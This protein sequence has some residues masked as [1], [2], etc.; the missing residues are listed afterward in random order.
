[1]KKRLLFVVCVLLS[2]SLLTFGQ[3]SLPLIDEQVF[4]AGLKHAESLLRSGI[5]EN[6]EYTPGEQ[7][8]VK[9]TFAFKGKSRFCHRVVNNQRFFYDGKLQI[10]MSDA[11]IDNAIVS[12][13]DQFGLG[14]GSDP[15][16][17]GPYYEHLPLSEHFSKHGIVSIKQG[18]LSIKP[19]VSKK[20]LRVPC[21][22][23]ESVYPPDP[24]L[25]LR[26]WFS[27]KEGF[28]CLQS[29]LVGLRWRVGNQSVP[30]VYT[31]RAV[32]R[33]YPVG[34]EKA[35]FIKKGWT[36]VTSQADPNRVLAYSQVEVGNFKPNAD[37]SKLF[38]PGI[39]PNRKIWDDTL[40]RYRP[41]KELG[42]NP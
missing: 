41:F 36:K 23:V 3:T 5:A 25:K 9:S 15:R 12:H 33:Q 19:D 24:K 21:Y 42:W 34:A 17:W 6:V 27:P 26:F 18:I 39:P 31:K 28:H 35:W 32:Y 2:P 14:F 29:Q 38:D 20:S 22:V 1:M 16:N 10:G 11:G 13:L 7:P 40:G 8:T 37:V 30:S 4:V